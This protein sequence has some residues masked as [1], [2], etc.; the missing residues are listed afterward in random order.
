MRLALTVFAGVLPED[1]WVPEAAA[2]PASSLDMAEKRLELIRRR[3][4]RTAV[5]QDHFLQEYQRRAQ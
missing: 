4:L 5:E 2:M 3:F 1:S